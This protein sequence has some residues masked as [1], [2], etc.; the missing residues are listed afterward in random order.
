M[1]SLNFAKRNPNGL[2]TE[3]TNKNK[4]STL[5]GPLGSLTKLPPELLLRIID[6]LDDAALCDL[7]CTCRHFNSLIFPMLF[8]KRYITHYLPEG[9]ISCSRAPRYTLRI[10]RCSLPTRK[11]SNIYHCFNKGLE[12]LEEIEEMHAIVTRMEELGEF[13]V[14]L[15]DPDDWAMSEAPGLDETQVPQLTSEEWTEL[16]LGLLTAAL[17]KGCINAV[18]GDGERLDYLLSREQTT[19]THGALTGAVLSLRERVLGSYFDGAFRYKSPFAGQPKRHLPVAQRVVP[20]PVEENKV[21]QAEVPEGKVDK[22]PTSPVIKERKKQS[23]WLK[24]VEFFST[25]NEN[26]LHA[27]TAVSSTAGYDS[28]N[29]KAPSP[30]SNRGKAQGLND[31]SQSKTFA[32]TSTRPPP[33][34][35]LQSL[36]LYSS[37]FL[38]SP[39]FLNWTNQALSWCA[40]TLTHLELDCRETPSGIWCKFL[41]KLKLPSL[42]SFRIASGLFVEEANVQ[43]SDIL[44]FLSRHPGIQKLYLHG[45]QVSA[46]LSATPDSWKRILPNLTEVTAHPIWISRLLRNKKQC[47]KLKEVILLTEYYTDMDDTFEYDA[48]D[49]ALSE[50][51]PRSHNLDLIGFKFTCDHGDLDS[52]LQS[53]VEAGP[54]SIMSSFI[55]TKHLQIDSAYFV[56]IIN[57]ASRLDLVA[58]V[59]GLFPNLDCL[60]FKEQPDVYQKTDHIPPLIQALRQHSPQSSSE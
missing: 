18:L 1:K 40:S 33:K 22:H 21:P 3:S 41:S 46:C 36:T 20:L 8:D 5:S 13:R 30:G 52:W 37:I 58:Q 48:M 25:K 54:N 59:A 32:P 57:P 19:A 43:G 44:G 2:K 15:S 6:E 27:E 35:K 17:A 55:N 23:R 10:I 12:H 26:S 9:W 53:H 28:N 42:V 29:S 4:G 34:P 7:G 50:I 60:E 11:F 14:F 16:Y 47:P 38:T 56:R 31:C 45:I 39:S 49:R 51:L 24:W